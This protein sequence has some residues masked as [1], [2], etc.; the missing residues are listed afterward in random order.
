VGVN[1]PKPNDDWTVV[2]DRKNIGS[3]YST[4][5]RIAV[6]GKKIK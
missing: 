5:E 1:S 6:S 2:E 4:N 3:A